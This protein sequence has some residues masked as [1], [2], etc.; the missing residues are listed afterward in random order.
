VL[1]SPR[2]STTTTH[3]RWE[4][5]KE[6][7]AGE[8]SRLRDHLLRDHGRTGPEIDGFPLAD[9]HHFEHVEQAMSL[10]DLNHRHPANGENRSR[11]GPLKASIACEE[12]D[13]VSGPSDREPVS[14]STS[15]DVCAQRVE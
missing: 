5:A 3:T 6:G 9:L 11:S 12:P 7:S 2:H 14:S 13:P 10:N 1:R 4:A 8:S 15:P